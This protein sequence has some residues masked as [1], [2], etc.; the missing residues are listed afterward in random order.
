MGGDQPAVEITA[1]KLRRQVRA[2]DLDL[3]DRCLETEVEVTGTDGPPK[4]QDQQRPREASPR[5]EEERASSKV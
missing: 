4:G 5:E 3:T 1:L 2:E